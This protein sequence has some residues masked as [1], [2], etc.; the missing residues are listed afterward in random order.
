MTERDR[1]ASSEPPAGLRHTEISPALL[2]DPARVVI[3]ANVLRRIRSLARA[4]MSAE[5]CGVLVGEESGGTTVIEGL[6][7]GEGA[8][9]AG[10]HVTFTQ[11]TWAHIY[12][13]KDRDFPDKRILGWYHSH[14]GFGIFLSRQD[15]FIHENFFS[16]PEQV[17]WVYDPHSD[18]EGCFGW[19]DGAVKRLRS[20]RVIETAP[21]DVAASSEEPVPSQAEGIVDEETDAQRRAEPRSKS[22]KRSSSSRT[23]KLLL[24]LSLSVV[25]MAGVAAGLMLLPRTIIMYSLP[26][27]R[28]LSPREV[29][30]ALDRARARQREQPQTAVEPPDK[31]PQAERH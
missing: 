30:A 31:P 12:L 14:P 11:D 25:F 27:G 17:A 13:V 15:L 7:E 9:K 22:R 3:A 10:T 28:L 18:E 8:E 1:E 24:L 6:I 4:E 19:M 5:V 20:I 21:E 23:K 16:A 2:A 29:Q 26:D